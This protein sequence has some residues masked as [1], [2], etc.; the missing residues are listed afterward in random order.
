MTPIYWRKKPP[1]DGLF[2]EVSYIFTKVIAIGQIKVMLSN[3]SESEKKINLKIKMAPVYYPD[4]SVP[5]AS[6]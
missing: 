6:F 1:L 5:S 4:I 2:K 3:Q